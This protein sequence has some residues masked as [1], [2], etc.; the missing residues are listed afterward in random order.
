MISSSWTPMAEQ[1]RQQHR[2]P[3]NSFPLGM[4]LQACPQIG[5][6][7]PG[8]SVSSWR[9]LMTAA[10]V[11]GQ[12]SVSVQAP[13]RKLAGSLVPRTR[14]RLLRAFSKGEGTSTP[15]VDICEI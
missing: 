9:D 4:V 6:Y 5:D 10:V 12:C 2:E 8:G 3:P 13:T 11:V 15:P 14:R 7:G 1:E